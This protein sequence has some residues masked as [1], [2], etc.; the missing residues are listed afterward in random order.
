MRLAVERRA[1]APNLFRSLCCGSWG[2]DLGHVLLGGR[3]RPSPY[4]LCLGVQ[5][6]DG[7]ATHR[8]QLSEALL[9]ALV[10]VRGE[11]SE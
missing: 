11:M 3:R 5:A 9:T 8:Q 4:G 2:R 7:N 10:S 1:R 6:A